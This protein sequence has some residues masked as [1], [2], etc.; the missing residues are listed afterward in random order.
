MA[1]EKEIERD[2]SR[3]EEYSKLYMGAT[4]KGAHKMELRTG[5]IPA[6]RYADKLRRVALAV[7]KGVAPKEVIIRDVSELNKQL[8]KKIVEEMKCE[9]GDLIRIVVDATY[10]EEE[11]RLVFD[12]PVIEKYVPLSEIE[13]SYGEKLKSLEEE[14][15]RLKAE[16]EELR[17]KLE[18]IKE[19]VGG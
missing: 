11:Q 15:E 16:N 4:L 2:V 8:F 14:V 9:K 13:K 12:E 1:E 19:I 18:K 7:F 5:V 10:D 17:K 3:A 6:A